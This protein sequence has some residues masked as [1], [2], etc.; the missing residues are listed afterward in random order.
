M[1]GSSWAGRLVSAGV[2]LLVI[3]LAAATFVVSYSG[4]RDL[5]IAVGVSS[6]LARLYPAILD[7]VLVVACAAVFML[8]DSSLWRRFYA[9]FSV[10]LMIAV[11]GAADALHAMNVALPKR[12]AAG[13]AAA[14]PWALILLGFSLLLT[15]LR[16]PRALAPS[17]SSATAAAPSSADYAAPPVAAEP[18]RLD[19]FLLPALPPAPESPVASDPAA[20]EP[21]AEA[22]EPGGLEPDSPE[23]DSPE[24]AGPAEPGEPAAADEAAEST[25]ADEPQEPLQPLESADAPDGGIPMLYRVRSI[26]IPPED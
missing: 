1:S 19:P 20:P 10:A 18:V 22:P 4:V 2:V 17:A 8:R 9:W 7:G 13:T 25:E 26:P 21:A 15:M 12:P 3:A 14:L 24:P 6:R 23:A 16:R 5:A 11:I